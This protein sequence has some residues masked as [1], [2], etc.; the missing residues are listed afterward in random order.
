MSFKTLNLRFAKSKL[1]CS[2]EVNDGKY[3]KMKENTRLNLLYF[4]F[5]LKNVFVAKLF[6]AGRDCNLS[7]FSLETRWL[8][9]CL[10]VKSVAVVLRVQ[11]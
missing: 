3:K 4:F 6:L 2:R 1:R 11:S 10:I 8:E 9:K 5:L 7:V